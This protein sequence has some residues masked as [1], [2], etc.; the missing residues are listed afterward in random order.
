LE[1]L[2]TPGKKIGIS[3]VSNNFHVM[4]AHDLPNHGEDVSLDT[5]TDILRANT[6]HTNTES[7]HGILGQITVGVIVEHVL[8]DHL[9]LGP[10]DGGVVNTMADTEKDETVTDFLVEVLNEAVFDLHGVDPKTEGTLLTGSDN[11][12]IDKTSGLNLGFIKLLKTM[13]GVENGSNEN[14]VNFGVTLAKI[15]RSKAVTDTHGG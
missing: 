7:L 8:G 15:L 2:V 14:R 11:I 4:D 10:V 1:C 5:L 13:L 12:V 9:G 3:L 6:N